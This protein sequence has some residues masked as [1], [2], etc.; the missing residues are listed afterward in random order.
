MVIAAFISVSQ[1]MAQTS[2]SLNVEKA[3]T[4]IEQLT[5]GEADK[6]RHLT[7]E[8]KINALDFVHLRDEFPALEVLDLSKAS[9]SS[10]IGKGGTA[11]DRKFHINRG[12]YIPDNAFSGINAEGKFFGKKGLKKVI[13]PLK[14]RGIGNGAFLGCDALKVMI[15]PTSKVPALA[16][17]AIMEDVTTLFVLKD[18]ES[19]FLENDKW[20]RF[21]I[22]TGSPMEISIVLAEHQSLEEAISQK[23]IQPKFINFLTISGDMKSEDFKII[24]DMMPN[25]VSINLLNTTAAEIPEFTFTQK[26]HLKSIVLPRHLER[27]GQRAFSGCIQLSSPLQLPASLTALEYGAFMDCDRLESVEALG[28]NITTLGEQVFGKGKHKIIYPAKK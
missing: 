17:D 1:A 7:I 19:K 28:N 12:Q 18:S 9:I 3:G 8:G 22:L 21:N 27:I 2:R 13:L 20:K 16:E 15:I 25:L 11:A 5:R 26:K 6:V 24:R 23:G 14:T 4:L 10:Y